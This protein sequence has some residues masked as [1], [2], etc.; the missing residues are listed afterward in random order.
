MV[1]P[2]DADEKEAQQESNIRW[3]L[4]QQLSAEVR[5]SNRGTLI[6]KI[7]GV[8]AIANTPSEKDS[9]LEVSKVI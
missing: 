3:P 8:M 1:D 2:H 9:I 6:W 7:N 4:L 5:L